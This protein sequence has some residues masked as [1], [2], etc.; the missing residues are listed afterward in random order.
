MR[1]RALQFVIF[2]AL[3]PALVSAAAPK[4]VPKAGQ[5][6]IQSCDAH[7]FET[8]VDDVVDGR[9][10]Q[11]QVK[12]CG[13]AGQSDAEWIDTLRD[14]IKKLEANKA[15]PA[16]Q[17]DQIV[18]AIK[19]EIG[20]LSIVGVKPAIS[21]KSRGN[22]RAPVEPLSRDYATLPPFPAPLQDQR[23]L[24]AEKSVAEVQSS[25][26]APSAPATA[27]SENSPAPGAI[28]P[29]AVPI[30]T[31]PPPAFVPTVAPKLEFGCDTPGDLSSDAPCA[32]FERETTITVHS[33]EDVPTGTLLQFVRNDR[34]QAQVPLE[35]LRRG[36]MVRVAL[37]ARVCSGFTSGKL[38]LRIVRDDGSGVPQPLSSDGPYSLRC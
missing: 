1:P 19:A 38:E 12:L 30:S 35:G 31:R 20:R 34:P 4:A 16:A 9:P 26:T 15:M 2:A 21:L 28:A 37:P 27:V 7:K 8:V 14:A 24:P 6:L 17:R 23:G 11:S 10:H 32:E 33:A 5:K 36:G 29:I 25:S 3:T 13:I 18:T 22:A